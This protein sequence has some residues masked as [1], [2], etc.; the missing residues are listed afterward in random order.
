MQDM[1]EQL[2][3]S[4]IP[5]PQRHLL[6]LE[7][8]SDPNLTGPGATLDEKDLAELGRIHSTLWFKIL[9]NFGNSKKYIETLIAFV[10]LI[11]AATFISK[12]GKMIEFIHEGGAGMLIILV[13]GGFLLF[14]ELQNMFRLLVV[15]DHSKGNLRLDTSSVMLGCL[16]LMFF[17]IGW[18]GLGVYISANAALEA[19][20]SMTILMM[21]VKESLT[22]TILSALV[23]AMVVLAHY[24]TRRLLLIW[25]APVVSE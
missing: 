2:E 17:G 21:G 13:L 6:A 3:N 1:A 19:D 7:L 10:P 22:P 14:K 12:E 9:Q 23:S 8:G 16:A 15:K 25:H 4:S 24:T 18:T 11:A 5:F 20:R